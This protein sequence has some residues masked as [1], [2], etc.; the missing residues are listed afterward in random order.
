MTDAALSALCRRVAEGRYKD[1]MV[2][3]GWRV[4]FSTLMNERAAELDRH[5]DR[6]IIDMILAHV[7]TGVS[8]SEWAYNRPRYVKRQAQLNQVWADM[9]SDGLQPA[10]ALVARDHWNRA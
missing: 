5:G 9:I 10:L 4:A 3:H 7:A 1:H 6:M 8:A 2:P